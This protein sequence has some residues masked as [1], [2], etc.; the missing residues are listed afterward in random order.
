MPSNVS[1]WRPHWGNID[2]M[3]GVVVEISARRFGIPFECP[4]CGAPPAGEI[5]VRP[6]GPGPTLLFPS[7]KR[8]DGHIRAWDTAGISSALA[9]VLTIVAAVA[10]AWQGGALIGIALFVIGA[11]IAW[12]VRM[13][14]RKA[15]TAMRGA[16]CA[17]TGVAVEYRGW[18]N[19]THAFTFE[20]P[21]FA[22]RFA[23]ENKAELANVSPQLQRLVDGY[24]RAR[25]AIPTPAVAAGIAPPP[26]DAREWLTRLESTQGTLARRVQLQRSLEM[27]EEAHSRRELIQ[28][29]ARAELA[30]VIAKLSRSSVAAKKQLLEDTIARVRLDNIP[31]ELQSAELH[32]LQS[33]LSE[34]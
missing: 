13:S 19:E 33:R 8:C 15:A 18:V 20:S 22:A 24:H 11:S 5:S 27:V 25:L 7:C 14:R 3:R 10:G 12:V 28:F 1:S 9:M 16:S 23:E 30:P 34:L 31:E 26:L 17:S 2:R 21:T 4:C 32:E 6:Y 29:V